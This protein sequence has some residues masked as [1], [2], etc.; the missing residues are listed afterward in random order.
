MGIEFA[1]IGGLILLGL[2]IWAIIN[3]VNS[4][5]STGGKVIWTLFVLFLPLLGFIVWLIAGPRSDRRL[6]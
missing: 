1:G 5:A 2:A 4:N 6:A 3:I